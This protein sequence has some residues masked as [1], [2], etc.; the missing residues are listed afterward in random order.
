MTWR[1]ER[2]REILIEAAATAYRARNAE[3]NVLFSP[4]WRDLAPADRDEAFE[5]QRESRV[6]ECAVD[7]EGLSAT[8]RAVLARLG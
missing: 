3:G 2:E 1:D 7:P 6:I 5:R 4:A 8:V